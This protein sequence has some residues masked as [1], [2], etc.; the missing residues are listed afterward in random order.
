[1]QNNIPLRY[2]GFGL[3]ENVRL[4]AGA[5]VSGQDFAL[6]SVVNSTLSGSVTLPSGYTLQSKDLSLTLP[7]GSRK[8]LF[9]DYSAGTSFSYAA[10]V[11]PQARLS[12]VLTALRNGAFAAV[13]KTGLAP[14]TTSVTLTLPEAPQSLSPAD[15]TANVT[16]ATPFSWT[17]YPQGVFVLRVKKSDAAGTP[18]RLDVVTGETSATIP[19]LSALGMSLQGNTSFS[20]VVTGVAPLASVD[21]AVTG[22]KVSDLVSY[23]TD[24]SIGSSAWRAFT[25]TSSP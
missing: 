9:T 17:A 24:G 15:Q 23:R 11:I 10:P 7:P 3:R 20:W 19:D 22:L 21:D 25:T 16:R 4:D 2:T 18:Y 14:D 6:G 5:T 1:M 12:L 13:S 8:T